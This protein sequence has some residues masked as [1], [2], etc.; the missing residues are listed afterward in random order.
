MAGAPRVTQG[1]QIQSLLEELT[2]K[3]E[4][5]TAQLKQRLEELSTQLRRENSIAAAATEVQF[6]DTV[7]STSVGR[8]STKLSARMRRTTTL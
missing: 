5:R 6:G 2:I 4:A 8:S 1:N 7:T 3:E